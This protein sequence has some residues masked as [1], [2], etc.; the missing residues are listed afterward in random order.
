MGQFLLFSV[1]TGLMWAIL[2][3]GIYLAFRILDVA[4]M[5]AEGAYP[6]GA[7]VSAVAILSGFPAWLGAVFGF[8]AGLLA[9]YVTGF[10]Q[11]KMKIPGLIAGILSMTA[12][13]SINLRIMGQA[14]L[15]LLGEET[16][17]KQLATW[18]I[19]TAWVP[20]VIGGVA[21]VL[22]ISILV[23]FM[24]TELGLN[25]RATGDNPTMAEAN[26][27]PVERMKRVGLAISS[28]CTSL[29]GALLSQTN[30]YADISMGTGVLV[31]GLA[32]IFIAEVL[33][34]NLTFGQRL[35]TIALGAVIYRVLI[36]LLMRQELIVIEP[37]DVKLLSAI[38]LVLILWLP[39]YLKQHQLKKGV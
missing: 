13:Y 30:G 28:G 23:G 1:G 19:P 10:L 15:S 25:L 24:Y 5:T 26:G 8:M 2:A 14:N 12:L 16:L 20:L 4:D 22:V 27:I 33:F 18:Q 11:T 17:S 6:L 37:S 3:I 36:D 35:V 39:S 21:I 38:A 32:A 31:I 7:A 9:G 34:Q 29:A